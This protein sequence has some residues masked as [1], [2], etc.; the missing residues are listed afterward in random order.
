MIHNEEVSSFLGCPNMEG[1]HC[2]GLINPLSPQMW[3]LLNPFFT[4]NGWA[5]RWTYHLV[6]WFISHIFANFGSLA[7]QLH[8]LQ[9]VFVYWK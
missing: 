3:R 7:V 8:W 6:T 1:F 9:D 2:T 5:L 4:S